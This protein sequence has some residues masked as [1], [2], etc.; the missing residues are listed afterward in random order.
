VPPCTGPNYQQSTSLRANYFGEK[1]I[2]NTAGAAKVTGGEGGIRTLG[3]L[4]RSTHDF[5]S[6]TF[7]RSVTSPARKIDYLA[8]SPSVSHWLN[9]PNVAMTSGLFRDLDLSYH[10]DLRRAK[11]DPPNQTKFSESRLR[12][13]RFADSPESVTATLSAERP[14]SDPTEEPL[15]PAFPMRAPTVVT[16]ARRTY[17]EKWRKPPKQYDPAKEKNEELTHILLEKNRRKTGPLNA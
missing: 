11:T 15:K 2:S 8:L 12:S 6:C 3:T 17:Q 10:T 13:V 14:D 4:I 1:P 9:S 5:Q 16:S 7:N